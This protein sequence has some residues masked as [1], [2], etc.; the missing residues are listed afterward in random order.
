MSCAL[1]WEDEEMGISILFIRSYGQNYVSKTMVTSPSSPSLPP[2][3]Y[4]LP[5]LLS[6]RS[7]VF[8]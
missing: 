6:L 3:Y 2:S 8:L 4:P 1:G 7:L 5:P